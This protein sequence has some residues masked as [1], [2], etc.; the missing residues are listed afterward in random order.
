MNISFARSSVTWNRD[1]SEEIKKAE[2]GAWSVGSAAEKTG[3]CTFN[4][5]GGF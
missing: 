3:L 4:S 2:T 5:G 1:E